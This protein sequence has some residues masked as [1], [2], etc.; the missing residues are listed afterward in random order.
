MSED[1]FDREIRKNMGV[2]VE[3]KSK[4]MRLFSKEG[5]TNATKRS[6]PPLSSHGTP[7]STGKKRTSGTLL[8]DDSDDEKTQPE[9]KKRRGSTGI[10]I[11]I[12]IHG[13]MYGEKSGK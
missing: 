10:I 3:E 1:I 6:T 7:T 13:E 4:S 11:I 8:A 9:S 5:E 12:I 2:D